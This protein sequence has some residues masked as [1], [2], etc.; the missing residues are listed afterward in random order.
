MAVKRWIAP[1]FVAVV[2]LVLAG[3][4][5]WASTHRSRP[6][7]PDGRTLPRPCDVLTDDRAKAVA[8]DQAHRTADDDHV[9]EYTWVDGVDFVLLRIITTNAAATFAAER[10]LLGR[11]HPVTAVSGLGDEAYLDDGLVV[12]LF[13]R[14]GAVMVEALAAGKDPDWAARDLVRAYLDAIPTD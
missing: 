7:M 3:L 1:T 4:Q 11:D 2:V 14:K 10:E 8:T 12:Q 6:S 13:A 9:C 5:V